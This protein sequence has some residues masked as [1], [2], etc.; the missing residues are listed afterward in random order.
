M[1]QNFLKAFCVFTVVALLTIATGLQAAEWYKGQ[2][3]CHTVWSDGS[4]LPEMQAQWYKDHGFHFMCLTDHNVLQLDTNKW[5]EIAPKHEAGKVSEATL[6]ES[7]TKFG[8]W[9]ETKEEGEGDGK[10]TLVRLKTFA[11]LSE[12]LNEDG[13]FLLIPGHEQN[14][15]I[16]GVSLHGNA[17]NIT[18]SIPFPK[19][20]P[21]VAAAAS[22]WRKA[23]LENATNSGLEGFWM[24]NHP[25]WPYYDNAPEELIEASEIE[26][27]EYNCGAGSRK[28]QEL[29][30]SREKYWDVI[31]AFRHLA[32]A[33]PIYLVATDDSHGLMVRGWIVVRSEKLDANTL[34][35]AMK[36]G[37][38][39]SSIGVALKDIR[40]DPATKTLSVEVDPAEGVNYTIK[41]VG[42]KKGFDTSKE[43]F[44]IPG[45][46]NA[47]GGALP[48][49]KGFTYSDQIGETFLTVEG[50]SASYKMAPEE[51]YV[52][53]IITS[54]KPLSYKGHHVPE[55]ET[56]W[57][58]PVGW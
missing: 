25:D 21:S 15:G 39:Y 34:F 36:S 5:K 12:K 37:D 13:R 48:A 54:D 14:V 45:D 51:L 30:P 17:I 1:K 22:A 42:T 32:G 19:D 23:T 44:E 20:F 35:R 3:H 40:F 9:A 11:E 56:A 47:T 31:L 43:P 16:A 28:L 2:F 6:K 26:F 27:L 4:A 33:K 7:R 29:M 24:I 41:F 50:T 8:D 55:T 49:R 46:A 38:F 10:K 18:A 58:Q 52:R 57:T 53:A